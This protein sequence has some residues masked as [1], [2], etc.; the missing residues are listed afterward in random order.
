M[1]DRMNRSAQ[2]LLLSA[3]ILSFYLPTFYSA[4][5]GPRLTEQSLTSKLTGVTYFHF[6]C[7]L[8]EM[9]VKM[10]QWMLKLHASYETISKGIL[11][12]CETFH[13]EDRPVCQG[14]VTEFKEELL[15]VIAGSEL[16][17]ADTCV[18]MFGDICSKSAYDPE[19]NWNVQFPVGPAKQEYVTPKQPSVS[20]TFLYGLISCLC[21]NHIHNHTLL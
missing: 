2:I 4:P 20:R 18:M 3:V 14:V 5:S 17:A 13:I 15:S 7:T 19:V 11:H 1:I 10:L 12:L 16:S 8:C 21:L 6:N 9:G